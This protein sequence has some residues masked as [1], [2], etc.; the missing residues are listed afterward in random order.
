MKNFPKSHYELVSCSCD[1]FLCKSDSLL[2]LNDHSL[3]VDK[4]GFHDR[5]LFDLSPNLHE[6]V[7]VAPLLAMQLSFLAIGT[8]SIG[9]A[10][11]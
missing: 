3:M 10:L 5:D 4:T 9:E 1:S 8:K 7:L 2:L 6:V 11:D